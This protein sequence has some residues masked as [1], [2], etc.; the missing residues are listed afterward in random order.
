[1]KPENVLPDDQNSRQFGSEKVRK[2]TVAAFLVNARIVEESVAG[3]PEYN[4]AS[5][6]LLTLLPKLKALGLFNFFEIKPGK[7]RQLIDG[8]PRSKDD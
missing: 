5:T 8:F 2:G 1:M 4:Q 3:S 6:D 7:V